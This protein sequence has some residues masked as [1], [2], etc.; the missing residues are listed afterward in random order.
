M[1][2][3]FKKLVLIIGYAVFRIIR[4]PIR[5]YWKLFNIKT[6]GV[7]ILIVSEGEV[8]LVRHWYNFLW[9]MPGGGIKKYE[10]P[11]QSAI[12]EMKEELGIEINQLDYKLG[13]YTNNKEGKNDIVHCFVVELNKKLMMSK[14]FNFEIS[15]KIWFRIDALPEGT[16]KATVNR[17]KEYISEGK[18]IEDESW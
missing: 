1:H 15:D 12:R 10:T 2:T 6:Y 14:K 18:N 7:R 16:S 3:K 5:L 13:T 9:V 8:V 4:T 11:E 17:I